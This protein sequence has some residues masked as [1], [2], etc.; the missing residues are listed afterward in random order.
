[1][2]VLTLKTLYTAIQTGFIQNFTTD[3]KIIF[4]VYDSL[5]NFTTDVKIIFK[6]YDPL[7]I[8]Y[9]FIKVIRG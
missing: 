3:V 9:L 4:K 2:L 6:V 1:M 5:K 8:S 7:K